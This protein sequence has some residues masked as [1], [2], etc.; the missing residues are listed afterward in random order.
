MNIFSK[1]EFIAVIELNEHMEVKL[2][3]TKILK[4]MLDC[5]DGRPQV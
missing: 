5:G 2:Y 4:N 1:T 3:S